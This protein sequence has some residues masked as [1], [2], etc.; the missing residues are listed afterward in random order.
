MDP[1]DTNGRVSLKAAMTTVPLSSQTYLANLPSDHCL[2]SGENVPRVKV[3]RLMDNLSQL[4]MAGFWRP[5]FSTP[6]DSTF[7]P[8]SNAMSSPTPSLS[9]WSSCAPR[10]QVRRF[11]RSGT[12]NRA[13]ER[14]QFTSVS[15]RMARNVWSD[16][17]CMYSEF[18][19]VAVPADTGVV[20]I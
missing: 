9:T 11:W 5:P 3:S 4:Y 17:R 16:M 13:R 6:Y 14:Q 1:S 7:T 8:R 10:S 15:A 19:S 2:G 12:R 18:L 20:G